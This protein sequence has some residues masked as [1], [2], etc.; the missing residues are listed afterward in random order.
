MIGIIVYLVLIII[1]FIV[2]LKC[3]IESLE[4]IE[5]LK[6]SNKELLEANFKLTKKEKNGKYK[7]KKISF[8]T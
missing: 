6:N 7:R 3:Y 5:E 2:I 1:A 4:E 8:K